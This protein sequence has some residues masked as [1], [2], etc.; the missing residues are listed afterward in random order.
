VR[1]TRWAPRCANRWCCSPLMT[2]D[3]L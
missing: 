3:D 1:L 2:S